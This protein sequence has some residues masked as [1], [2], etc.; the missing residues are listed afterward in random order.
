MDIAREKD[1]EGRKEK[2]ALRKQ[3]KREKEKSCVSQRKS[4]VCLEERGTT[5]QKKRSTASPCYPLGWKWG[6][7]SLALHSTSDF[8]WAHYSP[9]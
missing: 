8:P 7:L 6:E 3:G 5:K 4:S 2:K 1:K 9:R